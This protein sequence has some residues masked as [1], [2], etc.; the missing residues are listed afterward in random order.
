[1]RVAAGP[2]GL[3]P[4]V[5]VP[6]ADPA[7]PRLDE[8]R[9]LVDRDLRRRAGLFVGEQALVVRRMLSLP[10]LTRSVLVEERQLP[11]VVDLAPA[12]VPVYVARAG[13]LGEVVG[14]DLHRGVVALGYRAPVD[15]RPWRDVVPARP[16]PVGVL[17]CEGITNIDNV[18]MLFRDAAAFAVDAVILDPCCHDP[19]YRKSLRVGIGHALVVPWARCAAW[20][21]DLAAMAADRA[22]TIVGAAP[23]PGAI[24]LDEL[25]PLSR[26]ALVV[27]SEGPGLA[28]RTLACCD[29]LV[30]VPMAPG[31]DSLNVAVAAAVCLHRLC[32]R[33]RE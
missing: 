23:V 25:E 1:M 13:V 10:G 11:R 14:Y 16:G 26:W 33:G 29:R 5:I 17:V 28:P 7:D 30:R 22:L 2:E 31:V 20:P 27:G 8:Y 32:L 3:D 21:D 19:L 15:G 24:G 4:I 6:I 12:N 9:Y 18:G